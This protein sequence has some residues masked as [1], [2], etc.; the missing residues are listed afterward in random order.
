MFI[1][2]IEI[3]NIVPEASPAHWAITAGKTLLAAR[4]SPGCYPG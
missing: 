2:Q 4:Y 1:F 3:K